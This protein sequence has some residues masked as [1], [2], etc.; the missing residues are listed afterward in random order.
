MKWWSGI[1]TLTLVM[2]TLLLTSSTNVCLLKRLFS[3]FCQSHCDSQW[4]CNHRYSEYLYSYRYLFF[5]K[6]MNLYILLLSSSCS[7]SEAIDIP[8]R[9]WRWT[10]ICLLPISNV[11]RRQEKTSWLCLSYVSDRFYCFSSTPL[12]I[13]P[14][15]QW[16]FIFTL[17]ITIYQIRHV[18]QG[19]MIS[20]SSL[21]FHV[22]NLV[23]YL[24]LFLQHVFWVI[25]CSDSVLIS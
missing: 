24:L 8:C 19:F 10:S 23:I 3:D 1:S 13:R 21:K 7:S 9:P 11:E 15:S 17:G 18:G 22:I 25:F 12:T 2:S 16:N 14:Y 20:I 4:N 6:F 5:L